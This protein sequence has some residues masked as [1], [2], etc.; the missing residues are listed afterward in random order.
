MTADNKKTVSKDAVIETLE[1]DINRIQTCI[2][3]AL[4]ELE[5][6]IAATREFGVGN[7]NGVALSK[8]IEELSIERDTKIVV[9]RMICQLQ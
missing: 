4:D 2:D 5:K 9:L 7:F 8:R 3:C 6:N 1:W